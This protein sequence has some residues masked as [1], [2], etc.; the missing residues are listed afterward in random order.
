M[1]APE[2]TGVESAGVVHRS[3]AASSGGGGGVYYPR[4]SAAIMPPWMARPQWPE[5]RG[6]KRHTVSSAWELPNQTRCGPVL[7]DRVSQ[8]HPTFRAF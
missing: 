5:I 3:R 6:H 7:D 2:H 8:A 4:R 1:F